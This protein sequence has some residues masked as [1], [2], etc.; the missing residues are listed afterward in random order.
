MNVQVLAVAD[1]ISDKPYH[2]YDKWFR[3]I[4][5]HGHEPTVLGMG[6]EWKGLMTKP[7]TVREWL[8]SGQCSTDCL[9]FCDAFDL[10]FAENP[11]TIAS[12]WNDM[13]KPWMIGGERNLFPPG[14]ESKYPKCASTYRFPNSGFIISTPED[15]LK[16]LEHMDLD[17]IPND[18]ED[19]N[20]WHP[21][22]QFYF[23]QAVLDQPIPM[24]IDT[25]TKFVWNLHGVD[26]SNFDFGHQKIINRETGTCPMVFHW[27]GAAKSEGTLEPVLNRLGL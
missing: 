10:V 5:R 23:Q 7:R 19:P 17:K 11:D 1:H 14:D 15:M 2:F 8:K 12:I 3:S 26:L 16:V 18:G 24:R 4:T 9:I 20:N 25:E 13:G 27:N 6:L 21:N 22:D